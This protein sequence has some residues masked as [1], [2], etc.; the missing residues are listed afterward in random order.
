MP[1]L[2][3]PQTFLY[4]FLDF[5]SGC[6]ASIC[7]RVKETKKG[8]PSTACGKTHT[9]SFS[10]VPCSLQS[11]CYFD[12]TIMDALN[13]QPPLSQSEKFGKLLINK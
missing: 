2:R 11:T 7:S 12:S 4:I 3:Q 13:D 6:S 10:P 1:L 5:V 9:Q 8:H